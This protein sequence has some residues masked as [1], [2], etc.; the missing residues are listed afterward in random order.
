MG[1]TPGREDAIVIS[2]RWTYLPVGG[3]CFLIG[4]LI[5]IFWRLPF[6]QTSNLVGLISGL[7]LSIVS[8]AVSL[9]L[10]ARERELRLGDLQRDVTDVRIRVG[11]LHTLADQ[12]WA[13]VLAGMVGAQ[14]GT[15]ARPVT[16]PM[17]GQE[18]S[19]P[20]PEQPKSTAPAAQQETGG[21]P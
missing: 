3:I 13:P 14:Y 20:A 11:S 8:I 2:F 19:Q 6:D 16:L 12:M 4:L 9:W 18:S 15:S 10:A 21:I 1:S 17:V 5:G 7:V